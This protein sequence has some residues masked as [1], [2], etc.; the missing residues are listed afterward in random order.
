MQHVFHLH[1]IPRDIV[2]HRGPQFTSRVWKS[3]CAALGASVSL[4]SGYHPQSKGQT[5]RMNQTLE[6]ALRCVAAQ[7][8]T[9][10]GTYLPWVER[11]VNPAAVQLKLS[12]GSG[13]SWS[14]TCLH[15]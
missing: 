11:M 5:E 7:H 12:L 9:A 10:W 1:G 2:S 4:S 15:R 3:F 6:N 14:L 8:P 13:P